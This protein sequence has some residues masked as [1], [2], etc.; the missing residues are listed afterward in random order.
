MVDAASEVF[1]EMVE[2]ENVAVDEAAVERFLDQDFQVAHAEHRNGALPADP[3]IGLCL[4]PHLHEGIAEEAACHCPMESSPN[5]DHGKGLAHTRPDEFFGL[6]VQDD[7]VE[8][9]RVAVEHRRH[10]AMA[11][12][13]DPVA[14]NRIY[15]TARKS[16][17]TRQWPI[18]G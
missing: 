12:R 3:D 16:K 6:R 18:S 11:R 14:K 4:W 17:Q 8:R 10:H 15:V 13:G 7:V 5:S 2:S 1:L 9:L